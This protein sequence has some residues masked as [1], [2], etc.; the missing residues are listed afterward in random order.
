MTLFLLTNLDDP[1]KKGEVRLFI[2]AARDEESARGYASD[3]AGREE[4]LT[5][6]VMY[7]SCKAIGR[8][9]EGTLPGV[10]VRE[11]ER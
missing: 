2:I 7:S 5:W 3:Q 9:F 11:V 1:I 4:V 8:A 10:V 6:G